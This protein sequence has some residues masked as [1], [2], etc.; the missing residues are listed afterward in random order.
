VLDGAA[1]CVH[2]Q[3]AVDVAEGRLIGRYDLRVDLCRVF[4]VVQFCGLVQ[5]KFDVGN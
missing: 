4:K 3:E 5:V 2:H 1:F